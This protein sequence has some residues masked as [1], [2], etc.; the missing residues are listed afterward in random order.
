M[1]KGKEQP[2]GAGAEGDDAADESDLHSEH[3]GKACDLC[4]ESCEANQELCASREGGDGSLDGGQL[5][6]HSLC[7]ATS[8]A[9]RLLPAPSS[10]VA[11]TKTA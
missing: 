7:E 5:T 8:W 10:R 6:T 1:A 11:T 9:A 2:A 4:G 3:L